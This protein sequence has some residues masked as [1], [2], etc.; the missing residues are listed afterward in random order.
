MTIAAADDELV[1]AGRIRTSDLRYVLAA[2][3]R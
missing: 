3:Y 1:G 2:L